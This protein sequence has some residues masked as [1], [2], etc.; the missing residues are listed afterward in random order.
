VIVLVGMSVRVIM[1]VML[2][3]MIVIVV[4]M[5]LASM[6]VIMI[7]TVI[8]SARVRPNFLGLLPKCNRAN[9]NEGDD[10]DAAEQ[11]V[12]KEGRRKDVREFRLALRA[13]S[14]VH[15]NRDHAQQPA[16]G[17]CAE[18]I[19]EVRRI[20]RMFVIVSHGVRLSITERPAAVASRTTEWQPSK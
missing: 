15:Q 16:S 20:L 17:H 4:V 3:A 5:V 19:E 7:M 12:N 10:G 11:N 1:V 14:A 6:V 9:D 18:L 2:V 13:R 8:V